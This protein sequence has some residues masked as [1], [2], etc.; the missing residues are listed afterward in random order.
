MFELHRRLEKADQYPHTQTKPA[1]EPDVATLLQQAKP[2]TDACGNTCP[3]PYA[4]DRG[5][6]PKTK[7]NLSKESSA[8]KNG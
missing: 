2:M 1:Q 6:K 5:N 3:N 4:K 7:A 8:L